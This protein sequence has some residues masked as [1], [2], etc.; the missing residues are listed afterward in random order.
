M[1][2]FVYSLREYDERAFFDGMTAKYGVE[3]SSTGE[4]PTL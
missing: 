1:K 4:K 3:Y 2:M